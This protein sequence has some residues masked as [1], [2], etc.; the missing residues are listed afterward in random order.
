MFTV[1]PAIQQTQVAISSSL[2]AWNVSHKRGQRKQL[3]LEGKLPFLSLTVYSAV[4]RMVPRHVTKPIFIADGSSR[5]CQR[6]AAL[7]KT[8]WQVQPFQKR[9][10]KE[11]LLWECCHGSNG[12]LCLRKKCFIFHLHPSAEP[13]LNISSIRQG[14]SCTSGGLADTAKPG[15]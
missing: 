1:P 5:H 4:S 8:Q 11:K 10:A 12:T 14:W 15:L 6:E 3:C 9:Q 13:P 2:K 7:Q